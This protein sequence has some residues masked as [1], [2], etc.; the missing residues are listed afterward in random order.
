[1]YELDIV[2]LSPPININGKPSDETEL[3]IHIMLDKFTKDA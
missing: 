3:L 1:M 2:T